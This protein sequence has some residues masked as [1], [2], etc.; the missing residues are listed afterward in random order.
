M[1]KFTAMSVK[2]LIPKHYYPSNRDIDLEIIILDRKY[3]L[4]IK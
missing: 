4:F 2:S 1:W 3:E